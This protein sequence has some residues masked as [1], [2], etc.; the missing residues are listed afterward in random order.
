MD[1]VHWDDILLRMSLALILAILIGVIYAVS[2]FGHIVKPEAMVR[3][4]HRYKLQR[5]APLV[6]GVEAAVVAALVLAPRLG[7]SLMALHIAVVSAPFVFAAL[8]GK[9]QSECGCT[10]VAMLGADRVPLLIRNSLLLGTAIWL[11]VVAQSPVSTSGALVCLAV[12]GVAA[13][14]FRAVA[15]RTPELMHP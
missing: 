4:M 11:F 15:A 14:M 7:A 12:G 5:W 6:V 3:T 13:A 8:N 1:V 10:G 9:P 2:V